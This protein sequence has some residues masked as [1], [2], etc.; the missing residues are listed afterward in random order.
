MAAKL[1]QG[2]YKSRFDFEADFRLMIANAKQYNM[3]NSY[4]HNEAL[5]LEGFFERRTWLNML[6]FIS[7]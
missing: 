5:A 1:E 3:P 2:Q 7:I 6:V 4:V